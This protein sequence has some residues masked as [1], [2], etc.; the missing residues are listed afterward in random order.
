MII[1]MHKWPEDIFLV[2]NVRNGIRMTI[3]ELLWNLRS[4]WSNVN[5][6]VVIIG[7]NIY[8]LQL[9]V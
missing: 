1:F 3:T 8:I 9:Y 2:K 4:G 6:I 5:I 7:K